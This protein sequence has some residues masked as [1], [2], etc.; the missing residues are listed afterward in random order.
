MLTELDACLW[1]TANEYTLHN[2]LITPW[3]VVESLREIWNIIIKED[4]YIN[5]FCLL[6]ILCAF[7]IIHVDFLII[8]FKCTNYNLIDLVPFQTLKVEKHH[9][10]AKKQSF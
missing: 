4:I 1:Y 8:L 7:C 3:N 10:N 5:Y 9:K 6:A 2:G